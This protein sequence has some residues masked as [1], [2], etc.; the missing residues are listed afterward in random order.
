MNGAAEAT[1]REEASLGQLAWGCDARRGEGPQPEVA[2]WV[3]L[4]RH[5]V[6]NR[7]GNSA[8]APSKG[9]CAQPAGTLTLAQ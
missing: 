4:T 6:V 8:T 2:S 7:K 1:V 5:T 3:G 9:T